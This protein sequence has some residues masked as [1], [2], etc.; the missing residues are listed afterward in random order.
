MNLAFDS[1][2]DD[3]ET[4]RIVR[5]SRAIYL[6]CLMPSRAIIAKVGGRKPD[7]RGFV[8]GL[9]LGKICLIREGM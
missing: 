5:W 1:R 6:T 7:T 2:V 3:F 8:V 4:G 9:E